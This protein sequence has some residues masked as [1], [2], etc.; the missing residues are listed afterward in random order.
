MASEE[1]V[2]M[3]SREPGGGSSGVRPGCLVGVGAVALGAILV[4]AV[5]MLLMRRGGGA[6]DLG[7]LADYAPGSVTYRSTDGVMV[8]RRPDG[9]VVAFSDV[10]PHNPPGRPVCLVTYR[11]D[12]GEP[13][14][15]GVPP[16]RFFDR[17]T[18]ALYDLDGHEQGGDGLNLR[19]VRVMVES[20]GRLLAFPRG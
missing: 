6:V 15:G 14:A 8:V 4:V 1:L 10:D 12:L 2:A 20:K 5:A 16:G 7:L 3:G 19:T 17:C 18:G 11:P 13:G 9:G